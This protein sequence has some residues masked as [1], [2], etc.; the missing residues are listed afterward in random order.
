MFVDLVG[1]TALSSHLDPED[2]RAILQA[3]QNAVTGEIARVGGHLAKLMGDGVLAY[4]G[5]PRADEDDAERAVQAGLTI[6]QAVQRLRTPSGEPLAARVGI[7]TGLV[8]VGDLIG[9]GAS[10]EEAVVGETPNLAARLQEAAPSGT[11]VI[12]AGTRRLLGE[13]FE[14]RDLGSIRLKG[15]DRAVR[16]F[17]VLR[18]NPTESRFEARQPGRSAPMVGRDQEL[19]LVLERWRQSVAGEGQAVL[20][21]GEAGIGKSRLV[22]A[23]LDE[24]AADPH[25]ALRYQC[26]P[27]HTGTPLWPVVQQLGFAA[28]F[29]ARR[30]RGSK[31]GQDRDAAV[32]AEPMISPRRRR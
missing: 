14:L 2:M 16:G 12:A 31:T 3:Y 30:W 5:W 23:L 13:M 25:S 9:E 10:R 32:A 29:A 6:V 24:A 4:F 21:V 20:V 8:I 28:G 26:S 17:E 1:S 19:A 15:F 18:P 22:Q 27:H 11:V 7:A